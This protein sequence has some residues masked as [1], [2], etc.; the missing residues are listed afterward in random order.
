M[1]YIGFI[2]K[3]FFILLGIFV[4][5]EVLFL[6]SPK[7]ISVNSHKKE[8]S[9]LSKEVID[10]EF[11][12]DEMS[13]KTYPD[14][15]FKISTKNAKLDGLASIENL[16]F[17]ANLLKLVFKKLDVKDLKLERP[18]INIV[19]F[20][21]NTTNFDKILQPKW[22]S[23]DLKRSD[24]SINNYKLILTD[25]KTGQNIN[26]KG[27]YVLAKIDSDDIKTAIKGVIVSGEEDA[28]IDLKIEAPLPDVKTGLKN[29]SKYLIITGYIKNLHPDIFENY[30]KYYFVKDLVDIDGVI[31][32]EFVP[33]YENKELKTINTNIILD[34]LKIISKAK[35]NSIIFKG[36]NTVKSKI[37][38]DKKT[39]NIENF[40]FLGDNYKIT[41]KGVIDKFKSKHPKLNL[42]INIDNSKVEKL[43]WMLPS[44]L[45]TANDEIRK[46]KKYGAYGLANGNIQLKGD[47][48]KPEVY[49]SVNFDDVWILDGLPSNVPK[50][51]VKTNFK[52]DIVEVDVKVWA[53]E[54]EYVTV[55]GYSDFFDLS[56]NMYQIN[57]TDNVPL[58]VAQKMLPPVSDVL[59][60]VI[61]PVPMMDIKGIG[62]IDL[63]AG[64][65]QKNPILKGYFTFRDASAS[66]NDI[67]VLKLENASGRIDFKKDKVYFKNDT[68]TILGQK[69]N[70]EGVSDIKVDIDYTAKV[71]NAP[72]KE[73]LQT[74]KTS[75]MLKDYSKQINM[76]ESVDGRGDVYL[77]LKGHIDDPKAVANPEVIKLIKPKGSV[78][79]KN[80]TVI[81][82]NPKTVLSGTKGI[83][84]IDDKKVNLDLISNLFTSPIKINGKIVDNKA[85]IGIKSDKMKLVDSVKLLVGFYSDKVGNLNDISKTTSFALDMNYNGSVEKIDLGKV[86]LKAV[87]PEIKNSVSKI[88]VL[89]GKFLLKDG[90][91]KA[92]NINAKFYNTTAYMNGKANNLFKKPVINM[93]MSLYKFDLSTMDS[94]KKSSMLPEKYRKILNA[95]KDYKGVISSKLSIKNNNIDGNIWL[96]DIS[97]VHAVLD[98][99]FKI[100]SADFNFKNG[101]MEIHSLN[102][103]FA[104]TPV[105]MNG[106]IDNLLKNPKYNINFSSKLSKDFVDNYI[107]TNLSYPLNVKGEILLSSKIFG[108]K[109]DI[110]VI[111]SLKLEE[112]ADISYMGADLG[113]ENSIREIK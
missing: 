71:D 72:L 40:E 2:K 12:F 19:V 16:E 86:D 82:Q 106:N 111:P 62:N 48:L 55:K 53:T 79:I 80:A 58:A 9:K 50:A 5:S 97:F 24:Y 68:G 49:G 90:D 91:L 99:P 69:A 95:Y 3:I 102:S 21:D 75:P 81:I 93:D 20:K 74:L 84:K 77:N 7:I 107:N 76:L 83:I 38:V 8:I 41:A 13:V 66:F 94:I 30:L 23:L 29:K 52:K 87:F 101:N 51:K 54:K 36:K 42:D 85:D 60:F 14:F 35:E 103:S 98:Y 43:Y 92:D 47:I 46:I 59:G 63:E 65:S 88:D 113:E 67:K 61:G 22:F 1:K 39:L 105:F 34:D 32:A 4:L 108:T 17:K 73:L 109:N 10:T 78:N 18:N 15:S 56:N 28:K 89:S 96:R 64:G 33:S 27:D 110:T 104:G 11:S 70:I 25:E 31:N 57:S 45:F 6:I 26:I 112:G 100:N 37:N 44:T